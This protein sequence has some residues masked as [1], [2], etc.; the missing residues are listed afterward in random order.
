M[1]YYHELLIPYRQKLK[2]T[3]STDI[4]AWTFLEALNDKDEELGIY[5]IFEPGQI[6]D[7]ICLS[8]VNKLDR[9]KLANKLDTELGN[10]NY[11]M[12]IRPEGTFALE[13]F[14]SIKEYEKYMDDKKK[15]SIDQSINVV[16]GINGSQVGHG[17]F[18]GNLESSNNSIPL[19]TKRHNAQ[20]N[21]DA[22]TTPKK[23]TIWNIFY[24]L[25]DN[26]L[27]SLLMYGLIFLLAN[28]IWNY[29]KLP[30]FW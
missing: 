27:F 6:N 1:N 23:D 13:K 16:G 8:I 25:T 2:P 22:R 28:F 19:E 17:A 5:Y 4:I 12:S 20:P 10:K 15:P 26:K 14:N 3:D 11:Y 30:K 18:F 29:F 9:L 24:K 21:E 7:K